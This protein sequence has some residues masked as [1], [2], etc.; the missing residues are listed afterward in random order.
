M[1]TVQ[2][3]NNFDFRKIKK[4][5][6]N[7][8]LIFLSKF[9]DYFDFLDKNLRNQNQSQN[10]NNKIK[11]KTLWTTDTNHLSKMSFFKKT[12]KHYILC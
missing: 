9:F 4:L 7:Q 6:Q 12:K 2:R 8:I 3:K 10:Q 11:N 5:S 1:L